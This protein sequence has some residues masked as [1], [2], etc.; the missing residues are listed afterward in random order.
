[1]IVEKQGANPKANY[2]EKLIKELSAKLTKGFGKGF[3]ERNLR[4][5]REFYL[6]FQKWSAV[7]TKLSWTHFI[8][9]FKMWDTVPRIKLELN[10]LI[11]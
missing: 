6:S 7:R 4:N 2:G 9:F 3:N 5:M 10:L 11:N 8:T 1:M